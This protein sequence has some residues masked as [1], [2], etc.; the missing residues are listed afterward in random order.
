LEGGHLVYQG[1]NFYGIDYSYA[2]KVLLN[3]ITRPTTDP[4][5]TEKGTKEEIAALKKARQ[6][7]FPQRSLFRAISDRRIDLPFD[8]PLLICLM[9][10][11]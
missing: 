7:S 1:R 4:C 9:G 5:T 6:I 10:T 11:G 2:E 3:L 8:D